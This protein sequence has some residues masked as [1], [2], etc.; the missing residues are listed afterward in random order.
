M[1]IDKWKVAL[2]IFI[3]ATLCLYAAKETENIDFNVSLQDLITNTDVPPGVR[4]TDWHAISD[5]FGYEFRITK[6]PE[7]EL[8]RR[9][10]AADDA[11][12]E[13]KR[14]I[15]QNLRWR[16]RARDDATGE[17]KSEIRRRPRMYFEEPN[18]ENQYVVRHRV[19]R[20]QAVFYA[21]K[22]NKWYMVTT[23]PPPVGLHL[24]KVDEH[25]EP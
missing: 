9:I 13:E 17:E 16:L 6:E 15:R 21:R 12:G 5:D 7:I 11:T 8:N 20:A 14:Q 19:G 2:P 23:P 25:L 4:E 10:P 1:R 3:C 18:A 24:L 22:A